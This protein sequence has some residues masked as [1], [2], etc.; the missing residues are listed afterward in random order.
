[1]KRERE[2]EEETKYRYD[3]VYSKYLV[4]CTSLVLYYFVVPM[5]GYCVRLGS[6]Q[7]CMV[8]V[9]VCVCVC[10]TGTI[11]PVLYFYS[12]RSD[13]LTMRRHGTYLVVPYIKYLYVGTSY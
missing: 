5:K 7:T 10:T 9:C 1:M 3:T 13:R 8:C 11:L 4:P 6:I 2:I 12:W